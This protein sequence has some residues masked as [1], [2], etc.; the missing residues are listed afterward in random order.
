MCE[1]VRESVEAILSL[2]LHELD[3]LFRVTVQVLDQDIAQFSEHNRLGDIRVEAGVHT[4]LVNVSEDIG[5][6]RYDRHVRE[7]VLTLPASN[8]ATSGIT[9]LDRHV[10][11]ALNNER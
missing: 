6:E 10:K 5:R 11:I 8:F 2:A 9:V 7:L 3:R 4:L 1:C